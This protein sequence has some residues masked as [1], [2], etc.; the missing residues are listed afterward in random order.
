MTQEN[1]KLMLGVYA[2]IFK[3]IM[4][5]P[6]NRDYLKEII[7]YVTDIPLSDLENIQIKNTEHLI[8]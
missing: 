4:L 3:A 5:D 8:K 2:C 6:N 1:T 7:H